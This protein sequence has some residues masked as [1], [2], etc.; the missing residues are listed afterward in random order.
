MS[1]PTNWAYDKA[2]SEMSVTTISDAPALLAASTQSV[3]I[4]PDPVIKTFF[5]NI[6][7]ACLIA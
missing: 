3:P 7:P 1:A 4:G 5:P 2:L 6:F